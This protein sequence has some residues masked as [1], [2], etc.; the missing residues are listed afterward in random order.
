MRPPG[1][2][3]NEMQRA[4]D[5]FESAVRDGPQDDGYYYALWW[6]LRGLVVWWLTHNADA[7]TVE[8]WREATSDR[9]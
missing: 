1:Y 5:R 6:T 2:M 9:R 8:R 3:A 7:K 4:I